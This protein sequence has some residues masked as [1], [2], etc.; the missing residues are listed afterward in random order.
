[1]ITR[2]DCTRRDAADAMAPL[3]DLFAL[4]RAD[5]DGVIYL[6]GNS[7]GVLPK[8]ALDRVRDVVET[9]WGVGLIRSWTA[10]GWIDLSQRIGDKIARLIGAGSGEIAVADSTSINLFKALSAAVALNPGRPRILS[11]RTNFPT[12]LYIAETF[13]RGPTPAT[14]PDAC[15]T[16][17]A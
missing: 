14:A 7:L 15:T 4:D 5:R 12:D 2:D 9:E 17:Q 11:E 16:W 6:D 10:A 8:A 13:A 3:R 1:M